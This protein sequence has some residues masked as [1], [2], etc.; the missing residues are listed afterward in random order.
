MKELAL[1][2]LVTLE[3]AFSTVRDRAPDLAGADAE[4][5]YHPFAGFVYH[6]HHRLLGLRRCAAVHT[7]V[8]RYT[9][10]AWISD[11]WPGLLREP[12]D[13]GSKVADPQWN[14]I[15]FEDARER[16]ERLIRTANLRR[17]RLSGQPRVEEVESREVIW[18]PNW[19]LSGVIAGQP[20]KVLVDGLSSRYYVLGS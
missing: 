6:L 3:Q 7:L 18:K 13:E 16:S 1:A 4:L 19:L 2:P 15:T 9:G 14:T 5:K 20:V 10:K 11:A 8:D 17:Y 12:L